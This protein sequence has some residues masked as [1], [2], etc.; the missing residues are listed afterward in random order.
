M[1]HSEIVIDY[2]YG[3]LNPVQFGREACAPAHAYGPAVRTHWLLHYAVGKGNLCAGG[4]DPYR[5]R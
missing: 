2:G 1:P 3:G 5:V 4:E